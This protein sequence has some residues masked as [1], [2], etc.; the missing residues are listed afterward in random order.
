MEKNAFC[1]VFIH[2]QTFINLSERKRERKKGGGGEKEPR[3]GGREI[4]E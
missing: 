2:F 3:E 1:G 4:I